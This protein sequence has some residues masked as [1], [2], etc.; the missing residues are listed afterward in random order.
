MF[1]LSGAILWLNSSKHIHKALQPHLFR[2]IMLAISFLF[3][4]AFT[5]I[6]FID[7]IK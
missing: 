2:K 7:A 6:A 4:G 1:V 5:V 3:F